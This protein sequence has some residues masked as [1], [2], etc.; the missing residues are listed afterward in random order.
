MCVLTELNGQKECIYNINVNL[1]VNIVKFIS[2]LFVFFKNYL[3]ENHSKEKMLSIGRKS[4][5][6]LIF[7]IYDTYGIKN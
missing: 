7:T 1:N 3:P 2:E 6:R 5:F 4:W